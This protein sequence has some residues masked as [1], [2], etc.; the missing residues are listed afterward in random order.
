MED[1]GHSLFDFVKKGHKHITNGRITIDEWH[2][3]VKLIFKQMVEAIEFMH[4][5]NVVHFDISLENLLINDLDVKLNK[6]TEKISFV[7]NDIR[8]KICDFG[9][10]EIFDK[11]SSFLTNK[12]CGKPNY[13]SPES[14]IYSY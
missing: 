5:N 9:L 7:C 8:V 13:K 10:A 11:N 4:D 12:Y 6:K 14:L 1:G 3:V 2:K